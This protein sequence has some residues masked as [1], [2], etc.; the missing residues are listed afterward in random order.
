MNFCDA[1]DDENRKEDVIIFSLFV[2]FEDDDV[3]PQ[4]RCL[5]IFYSVDVMLNMKKAYK[6]TQT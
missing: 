1:E 4:K 3:L 2:A 5:K 6:Q